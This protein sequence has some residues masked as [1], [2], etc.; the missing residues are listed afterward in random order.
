MRIMYMGCAMDGN[1]VTNFTV[2]GVYKFIFNF[3]SPETLKDASLSEG[4]LLFLQD[5]T[6]S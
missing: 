6:I 1:K 3:I 4:G 5:W 2:S